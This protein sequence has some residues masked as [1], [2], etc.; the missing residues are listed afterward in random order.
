[1]QVNNTPGN[2]RSKHKISLKE[3]MLKS[4]F[5]ELWGAFHHNTEKK[6]SHCEQE[7]EKPTT[8]EPLLQKHKTLQISSAEYKIIMWNCVSRKNIKENRTQL[9]QKITRQIFIFFKNPREVLEMNDKITHSNDEIV[10]PSTVVK[11]HTR[12]KNEEAWR[13]W[14]K[15]HRMQR[16]RTTKSW[17][18]LKAG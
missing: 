11:E 3:C 18:L 16:T 2:V 9:L 6:T 14:K 4:G 15:L 1:M 5:K 10:E 17:N 13:W 8:T 12:D 7:S